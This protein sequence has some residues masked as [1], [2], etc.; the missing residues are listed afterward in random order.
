MT[1]YVVHYSDGTTDR[2]KNVTASSTSINIIALTTGSTYTITVEAT[3]D[4]LSGESDY[5]TI[6]LCKGN[7]CMLI[8]TS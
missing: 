1:G 4:H 5:S 6:T 3:S 8:I 7:V 2:S